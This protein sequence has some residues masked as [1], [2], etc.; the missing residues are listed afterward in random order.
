MGKKT[1]YYCQCHLRK[2]LGDGTYK[3]TV[4][5]LPEKH[6]VLGAWKKLRH[7]DTR[8]WEDGWEIMQ[9]SERSPAER[10]EAGARDYLDQ[11][12]ASDI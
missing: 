7:R 1:E 10:V 2:Q 8:E 3:A 6:A 9:V 4:T 5:W 11:R 12:S